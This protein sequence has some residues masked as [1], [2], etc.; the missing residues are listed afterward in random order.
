MINQKVLLNKVLIIGVVILFIGATITPSISGYNNKTIIQSTREV[1]ANSVLNDDFINAYWKFNECNGN[2]LK[3]S[4]GH[5]YDGTI[6]GATWTPSG[7][8]GC[9]L[10]FDGIDDYVDLTS[11]ASEIM[12]NK[13]DDIILS[14]Y[15]KSTGA[16]LIF[17]ATA[18]WGNNPEFRI[19]LV[20]NG[21][22]LF[23]KITQMCGII[24][25]ST[26]T[27]DNG[28]WHHAQYYFNGISS[29][30]TVTLYVDGDLDNTKTHWLCEIEND[31]YAKIKMGMHS[32]F[33]SDYYD[34]YIDEFKI[35]KYEQGNKQQP[36]IISGTTSG[37]PNVEY[38]YTLLIN[39]PEEDD[40][41]EIK[42]DWGDDSGEQIFT[43]P[44]ASGE[45]LKA[46]HSWTEE[47]IY[48]IRTKSMDIWD[49]SSWSDCYYVKIG[50]KPPDAP[51]ID[52]PNNGKPETSYK[53]S[54]NSTDP[55]GDD[56]ADYIVEWGDDS[57]EEIITGP[58]ASGEEVTGN[59]SWTSPNIY[60]IKAKGKDIYGTESNW[61]NFN[62]EIP[63]NKAAFNSLFDWLLERFPVLEVFL[64]AMNL[65][66]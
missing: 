4:S 53:F 64:R 26:G 63:R 47:G 57:G 2:T 37:E 31:D 17:S 27:Y 32:H 10:I 18:P 49:E 1:L 43:G 66:R 24:L 36:P 25:Y 15:F 55:D 16:G 11:Y 44:F 9:A 5:N 60:I 28:E 62:V 45:E 40:L 30:P 23:Y 50:N 35:I 20:S 29:N 59:H 51:I 8:D 42:I 41:L 21:S 61:T 13:T 58:F 54:F 19:E 33:S 34:G 39:D 14:F 38:E 3:D 7:Y 48:C 56:I 65:L 12:F 52:G 6:Y 22:L 46:F